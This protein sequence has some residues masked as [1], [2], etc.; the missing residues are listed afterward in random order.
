MPADGGLLGQMTIRARP[1]VNESRILSGRD[2]IN[3]H[4]Y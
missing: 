1:A 4:W 2:E 3:T